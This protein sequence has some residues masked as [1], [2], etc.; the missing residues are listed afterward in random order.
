MELLIGS[1]R[2]ARRDVTLRFPAKTRAFASVVL[3][4]DS[5]VC[6]IDGIQWL[7]ARRGDI[8]ARR[9]AAFAAQAEDGTMA[10]EQ[11]FVEQIA[12]IRPRR[13]DV[14]ELARAYV[15]SV[16]PGCAEALAMLRRAGMHIVLVSD[17]LRHALFPLA[18]HLGV[19]AQDVY[20]V[21]IRFDAVGACT[22]VNRDS[23][24]ITAAGKRDFVAGLALDGPVL[25]VGD[26]R[27]DREIRRVVDMFTAFTGFVS[28]AEVVQG[29][30][31]TAPSFAHVA[32]IAL[33][34]ALPPHELH[35]SNPISTE[36]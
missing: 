33:N 8:V 7:A 26:G 21:D 34:Q 5:T 18:A 24:L 27:S 20:G 16:A 30:D 35:S 12:L 25:A 11:V 23:P 19:D 9:V 31:A 36:P 28:R 13:P 4:V 1:E 10:P 3:D 6:G 29:A 15:A 17:S 22:W 32:S 2:H 14:D